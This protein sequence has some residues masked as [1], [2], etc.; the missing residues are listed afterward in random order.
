[1]L[2][3]AGCDDSNGPAPTPT[4]PR[5]SPRALDAQ[6]QRLVGDYQ[7]ISRALTGYEIA[8]R[9]AQAGR[10]PHAQLIARSRAFR[11]V[12]GTSL[13]RVR[14]DPAVG[15][16]AQAKALLVQALVSR[17]RALDALIESAGGYEGKWNRSVV[18]AR[19]ALT[20]LQDIRDRA[21]LIPLPEDSIS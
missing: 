14:R 17:R 6:Q 8:F 21:R 16:T 3:L 15:A 12:V 9:D 4:T 19:R 11:A 5:L 1:M 20:K 2:L 10:L 13:N 7:P 18:L